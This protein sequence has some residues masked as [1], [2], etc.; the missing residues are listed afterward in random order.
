MP[1]ASSYASS[2]VL[3]TDI[4]EE[5]MSEFESLRTTGSISRE[6]VKQALEIT[7]FKLTGHEF[8]DLMD[9]EA[10]GIDTVSTEMF[11]LLYA[12]VREMKDMSRSFR[13]DVVLKE[14][15]DLTVSSWPGNFN[16]SVFIN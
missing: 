2:L 15:K 12:K 16:F 7:G 11:A 8:R 1:R 13:K 14:K 5:V 3:D 4:M 10:K 6:E 9:R